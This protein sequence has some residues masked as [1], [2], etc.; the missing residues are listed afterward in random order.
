MRPAAAIFMLMV[1]S[2]PAFCADASGGLDG[3]SLSAA[4]GMDVPSASSFAPGLKEAAA[5]DAASPAR[6]SGPVY[7]AALARRLAQAAADGNAGGF[8]G[9]CYAYVAWH[10]HYAGILDFNGWV[11]MG[12]QPGYSD[13]AAD[14]FVWADQNR[15]KM[16]SEMRLAIVPTPASKDEVPVGSILVYDRGWCGFSEA[17]GHIEVLTSPDWACSDGCESLDNN[18]F[19][20][21]SVREHVHV[22]IPVK[23]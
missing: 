5:K 13:D 15:E 4:S 21:A 14:F 9:K 19:A 12:I 20:D 18:C 17:S 2:A 1:L 23:N 10:M 16:R 3:L 6:P 22:I 7:D 8:S 11:D